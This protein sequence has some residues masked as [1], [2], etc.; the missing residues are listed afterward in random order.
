MTALPIPAAEG[1]EHRFAEVGGLRLHY[2]E[3]GQGEPV[4]LLHG[5]P[6]HWYAWHRQIPRLARHYRVICPDLRGFGWSDAPA[7][8]Y[9]KET[10][11]ADVIALMDAL[12]IR[13]FRL[14]GHDWGG[15]IGF[16]LCLKYPERIR[17][18]LALSIP[19][20]F[21]RPDARLLDGW[22]FW[23]QHLIAMPLLGYWLVK[24][25]RIVRL[26]LH[27]GMRQR[28]WSAGE[29]EIYAA[30]LRQPARAMA[31]VRLYR[32]FQLRELT[33]S[34]LGRYR[35]QRL[36]TRTVMLVGSHDFATSAR[37][38]AGHQPYCDDLTVELVA[39]GGHFLVEEQPELITRRALA[40]FAE[41]P[42]AAV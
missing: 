20:V 7:D 5:W 23:Y 8:G 18:S 24:S 6:Q 34:V 1:V 28:D 37:M 32:T 15:W 12:G 40:F 27:L 4:V 29:I 41:A 22:R 9:D 39:G 38:L 30:P 14:M 2:A 21:Q 33:A 19:H 42:K 11:A 36:V 26:V 3:A 31:S 13:D 35:S 17:S 25:A 16:L 10:L